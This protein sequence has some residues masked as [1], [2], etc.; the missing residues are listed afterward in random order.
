[1]GQ[2]SVESCVRKSALTL[3]D[4]S[5]QNFLVRAAAN[6]ISIAEITGYELPRLWLERPQ[7]FSLDPTA[8]TK[9]STL[10]LDS[11]LGRRI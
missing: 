4:I 1:M 9:L 5:E 10:K 11:S 2:K 7:R 6:V 3:E 8:S